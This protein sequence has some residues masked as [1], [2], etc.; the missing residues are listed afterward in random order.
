MN[1]FCSR[2][3][4]SNIYKTSLAIFGTVGSRG[5]RVGSI[6]SIRVS[7][8]ATIS[9]FRDKKYCLVMI[10]LMNFKKEVHIRFSGHF[11]DRV[12][13]CSVES[14]SVFG[15]CIYTQYQIY[16]FGICNISSLSICT[17]Y[18]CWFFYFFNRYEHKDCS[19]EV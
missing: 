19:Q 1:L 6:S 12:Y 13:I 11:S 7:Q 2:L 9:I 15:F 17:N 5:F 14:V 18:Y 16:R 8:I 10:N 3:S 4:L